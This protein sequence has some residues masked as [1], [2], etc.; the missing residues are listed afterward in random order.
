TAPGAP[1]PGRWAAATCNAATLAAA[2]SDRMQYLLIEGVLG[3]TE[4]TVCPRAR[5]CASPDYGPAN[6]P[7]GSSHAGGL[8][9]RPAWYWRQHGAGNSVRNAL[10][11]HHADR[12]LSTRSQRLLQP[13]RASHRPSS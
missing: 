3:A 6:S 8:A 12:C 13:C 9:R 7:Y 1:P 11:A 10:P 2:A 4:A 5:D